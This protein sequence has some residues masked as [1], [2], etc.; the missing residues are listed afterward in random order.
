MGD[1]WLIEFP[2]VVCGIKCAMAVQNG[3]ADNPQLK[4]RMGLHS[5]D[6]SFADEDVYGDGINVATPLQDLA[7]PGSLVISET[8][9]CCIDAKL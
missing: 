1:G 5:G 2:S 8:A 4:L 7:E 3:L 9:R 6:V